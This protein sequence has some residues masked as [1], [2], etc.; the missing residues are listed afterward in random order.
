ML[1]WSVVGAAAA[2]AQ[3]LGWSGVVVAVAAAWL[4]GWELGLPPQFYYL[5]WGRGVGR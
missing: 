3:L 2:A 1:R 5:R 4:S